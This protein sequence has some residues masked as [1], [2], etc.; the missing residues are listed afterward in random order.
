MRRR[1]SSVARAYH[2]TRLA[3][4]SA[5]ILLAAAR[6]AMPHGDAQ[7]I[8][9]GNFRAQ[10]GEHCCGITDCG[11]IPAQDVQNVKDGYIVRGFHVKFSDTLPSTD[12]QYWGCTK[13]GGIRCFFAPLLG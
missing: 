7:W 12:G 2:L 4:L 13:P 1:S 11:A 9:N 6:T 8:Q 3:A 10:S 5:A